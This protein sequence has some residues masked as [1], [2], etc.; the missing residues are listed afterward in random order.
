MRARSE[1][2]HL[3]IPKLLDQ[4]LF[5][6][7]QERLDLN[8]PIKTAPRTTNSSVLLSSIARCGRC[9]SPLRAQTAKSNQ[10]RY[11]VCGA[12]ADSGSTRCTGVR[13]SR[14][15]L[16]DEV[17]K[18][19]RQ[20][21]LAPE[22]LM[23]LI[24]KVVERYSEYSKTHIVAIRGL[25]EQKRQVEK[26]IQNLHTLVE[27]GEEIDD[28]LRA[29]FKEL[30]NRRDKI[31]TLISIQ[32]RKLEAPATQV[33]KVQIEQFSLAINERLQDKKRPRFAREYLKMMIS[34]V[35][36]S[37][38]AIIIRGSEAA[39]AEGATEFARAGQPVLS[40]D[41]KWR[42]SKEKLRTRCMKN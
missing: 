35:R 23:K 14:E 21:V 18:T 3:S 36:V 26:K 41:Q 17:L 30:R 2:I 7:V 40:F 13:I 29:R 8:H 10:Y 37:D 27:D 16:D 5:D 32:K 20:K 4:C 25:E 15:L 22:R 28:L 1:W 9:G 33:S 31:S 39:L 42:A 6:A 19:F 12:K 11:Y 38:E 24:T 34:E